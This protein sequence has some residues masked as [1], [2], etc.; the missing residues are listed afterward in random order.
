MYFIYKLY[1]ASADLFYIGYTNDFNRRLKEHNTKE[2][3]NTYTSK[4][5]PWKLAAVFEC[6]TSEGNAKKLESFIKKQKS[7]KLIE[8]L[9]NPDFVLTGVLARLSRISGTELL[10]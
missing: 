3:F 8:M 4:Y 1:S 7:R 6:G 10:D 9:I 2:F 5:R